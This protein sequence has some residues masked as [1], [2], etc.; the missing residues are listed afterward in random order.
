VFSSLT[1]FAEELSVN[2]IYQFHLESAIITLSA[3]ESGL[4]DVVRGEELIGLTR[5]FFAAGASTL[6][7][8]LWRVSDDATLGLM[9]KLYAEFCG[10]LGL[11]E[12]L[13]KAQRSLIGSELH[14]YF[15]APFIVSG[16]W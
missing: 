8:S 5:A 9:N 16:K 6:L 1:L 10:G 12:S 3:C 7:L 4:N 2:K 15:W 11:S 13:R 14:P